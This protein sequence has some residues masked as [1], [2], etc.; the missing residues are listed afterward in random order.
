MPL[1]VQLV[2]E[3]DRGLRQIDDGVLP[4]FDVTSIFLPSAEIS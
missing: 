2:L 4:F 3:F 1:E